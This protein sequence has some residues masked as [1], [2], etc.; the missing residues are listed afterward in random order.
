MNKRNKCQV[1][2]DMFFFLRKLEAGAGGCSCSCVVNYSCVQI[3]SFRWRKARPCVP[4]DSKESF[5]VRENI[6]WRQVTL[7]SAS[8]L[9]FKWVLRN[10]SKFLSVLFVSLLGKFILQTDYYGEC[11]N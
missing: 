10:P 4:E 1:E 8:G 5:A 3:I 7:V 11:N 2:K 9:T 6:L